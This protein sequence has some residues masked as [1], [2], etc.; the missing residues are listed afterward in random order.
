MLQPSDSLKAIPEETKRV[1]QAAF[2]KGSLAMRMRDELGT[3]YLDDQFSDLFPNRGQPAESPAML[4]LVVVLQFAEGLTDRQAADAVRGRID[5]K[6][7]LG[8][9]LT[10]AGFDFTVLSEFRTRLA[11]GDAEERLLDTLLTAFRER[12]LLKAGGRQRTDSTHVLANLRDL[13]RLECVGETLRMA[14]NELAQ[15]APAWVK[16]LVPAEWYVRYGRRFDSMH[17][18]DS[19]AKRDE[20]MLQIGEDG[21]WLMS[22]A[23]APGTLPEVRWAPSVEV[24]R[25][26][27]VQQY[28]IN[29]SGARPQVRARHNDD[30]PPAAKRL[31]SPYDLEARYS[32]R[33]DT[34]WVG[35]K[36][37]LTESCDADAPL[38][39]ITHVETVPATQQDVEAPDRIHAELAQRGLTPGEHLVDAAYPSANLLVEAKRDYGIQIVSPVDK[40]QDVSWQAREHTGYDSSRFSID[41]ESKRVTCPQGQQSVKWVDNCHDRTNNEVIHVAFD[42]RTCQACSVRSLCTRSQRE[43]RNLQLRPR[44]QHEALQRAR[45]E[46]KSDE[47]KQ[48]YKLRMGI[49]GTISQGVRGFGLRRTRYIGL[50]KAHLQAVAIAAAINLCRFSDYLCGAR[51][52]HSVISPFAALAA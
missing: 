44:E 16:H 19:Q 43:G 31:Q 35:Y 27:W 49:E 11:K 13:N 48:K 32:W 33:N 2:P 39:L 9:D 7:A 28:L 18:P 41:W 8:L 5:W 52:V 21:F 14:L 34:E 20:L 22:H 45:A 37:H 17:E 4:A 29:N 23:F 24:L 10:D 3:V 38:N 30:M 46:G 42:A 50:A 25:R 6:Y 47:F 15:L 26:I 1:A 51:P 36:V 40:L 12:G